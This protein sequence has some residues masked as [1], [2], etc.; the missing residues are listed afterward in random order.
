MPTV[1]PIICRQR[2][3]YSFAP[4]FFADTA[5]WLQ[6]WAAR[7]QRSPALHLSLPDMGEGT[8]QPCSSSH[9]GS[10]Q[11]AAA[12]GVLKAAASELGSRHTLSASCRDAS[13]AVHPRAQHGQQGATLFATQLRAGVL[14]QSQLQPASAPQSFPAA[15]AWPGLASGL[16][17]REVG[18]TGGLGALGLLVARWL[19]LRGCAG[20]HLLGRSGRSDSP[21]LQALLTSQVLFLDLS[22]EFL[23][24]W[25]SA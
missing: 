19:A 23:S 20:L 3:V 6:T 8:P 18:V 7:Q 17:L 2:S 25:M 11:A 15:A 16:Q 1:L 21:A 24:K 5:H 22:P 9:S 14:L 10:T 4:T 12:L 13:S